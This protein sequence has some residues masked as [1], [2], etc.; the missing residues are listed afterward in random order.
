[1]GLSCST[2]LPRL[3]CL[4]NSAMPPAYLNSA[5]RASPVLASAVRSSVS[6]I[7]RPLLR[8]AISRRR[9]ASVS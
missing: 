9:W 2:C 4:T 8:K 1:M 3:R 7:S 6:V 5:R